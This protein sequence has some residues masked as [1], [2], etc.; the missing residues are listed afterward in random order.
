MFCFSLPDLRFLARWNSETLADDAQAGAPEGVVVAHGHLYVAYDKISAAPLAALPI[1]A[2][3]PE[4]QQHHQQQLAPLVSWSEPPDDWVFWGMQLGPDGALYA[5]CNPPYY[6]ATYGDVPEEP[7]LGFVARLAPD[8][9]GG[10][11]QEPSSVQ[12]AFGRCVGRLHPA[13]C[14]LPTLI[15]QGGLEGPWRALLAATCCPGPAACALMRP[16]TST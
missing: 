7:C 5:A 2:L 15:L 1:G 9:H 4:Q 11:P 16:G 12:H 13:R 8:K 3:E 6:S 10:W 14:R